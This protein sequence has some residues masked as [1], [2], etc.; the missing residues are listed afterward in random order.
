[1][2]FIVRV[3][4]YWER[5]ARDSPSMEI[6]MNQLAGGLDLMIFKSSIPT[7]SIIWFCDYGLAFS[8]ILPHTVWWDGS[9]CWYLCFGQRC[10]HAW[11]ASSSS[12]WNSSLLLLPDIVGLETIIVHPDRM[13]LR[14]QF[15]PNPCEWGWQYSLHPL[16]AARWK[17]YF[18][19]WKVEEENQRPYALKNFAKTK[20][21]TTCGLL[22]HSLVFPCCLQLVGDLSATFQNWIWKSLSGCSVN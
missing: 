20:E 19:A 16:R 12:S 7:Q 8:G 18:Q 11:L 4:K 21:K 13:Q 2:F 17:C 6:L 3:T 15:P 14:P 5:L 10:H 22:R 1:M 9:Y